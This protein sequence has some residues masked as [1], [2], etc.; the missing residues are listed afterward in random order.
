[1]A[2]F[3]L[4]DI[5]F[6][7]EK[8]QLQ[9]PS[10]I[11]GGQY[12]YNTFRYPLDVGN[13]DKGHYMVFHIYQQEKTQFGTQSNVVKNEISGAPA[14][15]TSQQNLANLQRLTGGPTNIGG[16]FGFVGDNL[17]SAA[18]YIK[19][20]FSDTLSG[21]GIVDTTGK[22][23]GTT[24][25]TTLRDFAKLDQTTFLRRIQKTTDTIALYMPDTLNFVN[26][27]QYSDVQLGGGLLSGVLAG[28]SSVA[29]IKGKNLSAQEIASQLG[30][31][32]SPFLTFAASRFLN[33]IQNNVGDAAFAATGL[34]ANPMLELLYTSP[35]LREFRFDFLLYPRSQKEAV[36]VQKILD[37]FKF[38]QAP[39]ILGNTGGFF[40]VP[41]SMFDIK[42]YYNGQENPNIP[43][44]STCVLQTI[45]VDY[46]P[47]GTFSTY[48]VPG[49]INPQTGG[50]G[51]PV[52]IRLSLQFKEIDYLTKAN[53]K[54][55]QNQSFGTGGIQRDSLGVP[56]VEDI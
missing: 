52:A 17:N 51:M 42:F 50:T 40:M 12:E 34:A 4:T 37:R 25:E 44:I 43:K 33:N 39:E 36:E 18:D 10:Q 32:A 21:K 45:D 6:N 46:A 28:L 13:V 54:N 31:Q 49:Q 11:V 5:S 2:L 1:M 23:L 22:F 20:N 15:S 19:T 30:K 3:S 41:P 24:A 16:L 8:R 27:Q 14:L 9:N 29:G 55:Q 53:F 7:K 48:E 35:Q 47:T 56:L 26:S 38:H